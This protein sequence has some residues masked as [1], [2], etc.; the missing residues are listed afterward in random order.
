MGVA[1]VAIYYPSAPS[2]AIE[3]VLSSPCII[4]CSTDLRAIY[5]GA[6]WAASRNVELLRDDSTVFDLAFFVGWPAWSEVS[7]SS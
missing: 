7:I 2:G 4:Y 3:G 1:E 5:P 6:V